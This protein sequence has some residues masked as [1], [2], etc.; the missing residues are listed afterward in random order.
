MMHP[1]FEKEG[2]MVCSSVVYWPFNYAFMLF[3]PN[4]L[5]TM[6][7][8]L[9]YQVCCFLFTTELFM[10][11][12]PTCAQ[13]LTCDLKKVF[14]RMQN[15]NPNSCGYSSLHTLTTVTTLRLSLIGLF[16]VL[17]LTLVTIAQAQGWSP[18]ITSWL[19]CGPLTWSHSWSSWAYGSNLWL[20]FSKAMLNSLSYRDHED[21]GI[22]AHPKTSLIF[23]FWHLVRLSQAQKCLEIN[24]KPF[25]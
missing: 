21:L 4:F 16:A 13:W 15:F 19:L 12:C 22:L 7:Y 25:H 1:K 23:T 9:A 8:F 24:A 2:S 17:G 18:H 5:N 20:Q 10:Q 14:S 11:K 6:W 3:V